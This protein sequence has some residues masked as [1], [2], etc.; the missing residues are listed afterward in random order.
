MTGISITGIV[1]EHGPILQ[2]K[3]KIRNDT[4]LGKRGE[5]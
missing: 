4:I 3:G 1:A 5:P 2:W